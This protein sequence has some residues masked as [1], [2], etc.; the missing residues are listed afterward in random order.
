MTLR[1]WS[2]KRKG[3]PTSR[4]DIRWHFADT[5]SLFCV[6][7]SSDF[8]WIYPSCRNDCPINSG[9]SIEQ[10]VVL[11]PKVGDNKHK[12]GVFVQSRSGPE[13]D[14]LAS[15]TMW[16]LSQSLL[17]VSDNLRLQFYLLKQPTKYISRVSTLFLQLLNQPKFKVPPEHTQ[18]Y[19]ASPTWLYGTKSVSPFP[20]WCMLKCVKPS[21]SVA[22][23]ILL[24]D[25]LNSCS[26]VECGF[27]YVQL[28]LAWSD[29]R[30]SVF[31]SRSQ[32]T[33]NVWPCKAIQGHYLSPVF[34]SDK[35]F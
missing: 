22:Y 33:L 6:F 15:S 34:V 11:V 12:Y 19:L 2:K 3:R 7:F 18:F 24:K 16:V 25:E 21:F 9:N 4:Q 31:L 13:P 5:Y 23:S 17:F 30:S 10:E 1:V 27:M 32:S 14:C 35:A 26:N 8:P 28:R 20:I 29:E